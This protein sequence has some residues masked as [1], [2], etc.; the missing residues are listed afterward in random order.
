MVPTMLETIEGVRPGQEMYVWAGLEGW[1]DALRICCVRVYSTGDDGARRYDVYE[2]R[3]LDGQ[4][5]PCVDLDLFETEWEVLG[6]IEKAG[7]ECPEGIRCVVA[8][9]PR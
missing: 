6:L 2:T 4:T 5:P 9:E 8:G 7:C 3:L 1:D